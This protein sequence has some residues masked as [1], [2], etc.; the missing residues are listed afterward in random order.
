MKKGG[1]YDIDLGVFLNVLEL[2][3]HIDRLYYNK[4]SSEVLVC[5]NEWLEYW[6]VSIQLKK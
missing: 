2:T 3:I 6:D 1:F 5:I 4:S